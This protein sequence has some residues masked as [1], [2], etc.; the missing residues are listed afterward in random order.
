VKRFRIHHHADQATIDEMYGRY[1]PIFVLSTGRAGSRLVAELLSLAPSIRACHEPR[2]T[3]QY[4]SDF[5]ARHQ[6]E[7]KLLARMIDA[8][9]ME[10]VLE[11]F[12][13]CQVFVE[14]NQCLTFFAPALARVFKGAAFVHLVRHP[15]DFVASAARKGWHSNDSVW[16]SGRVRLDDDRR[17]SEMGPVERLGWVWER[18]NRYIHD[19]LSTLPPEKAMRCRLEDLRASPEAARPLFAFCGQQFPEVTRVCEVLARPV[20]ALWI[21]PDEPQ[22]MKKNPG[23]P[24]YGDWPDEEKRRLRVLVEDTARSLGYEL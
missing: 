18:T 9:R 24:G 13:D 16:E 21:D 14:S 17:W 3:L 6:A 5:A 20:S 11:A 12:V 2:P 19:F 15:G 10:L 22:N 23:F 8:A 1:R 4:F 7:P